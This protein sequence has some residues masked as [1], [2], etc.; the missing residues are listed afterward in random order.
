MLD[1]MLAKKFIEKIGLYTV[2]SI[3]IMGEN[4]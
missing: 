4:G 1:T 3:N 2:Y